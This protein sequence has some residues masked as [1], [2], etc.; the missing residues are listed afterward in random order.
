M[1][2][3]VFTLFTV[4]Y[5]QYWN[6]VCWNISEKLFFPLPWWQKENWVYS[7][8]VFC[9]PGP[10]SSGSVASEC[11]Y[12][13]KIAKW[14]CKW[15][16]WNSKTSRDI[17]VEFISRHPGTSVWNSLLS[18][19]LGTAAWNSPLFKTSRDIFLGFTTMKTREDIFVKFTTNKTSRDLLYR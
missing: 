9:K 11:S 14:V 2:E 7:C 8:G 13:F 3:V 10:I 18:K 5:M 4:V 15:S 17:S 1:E 12:S 6:I 19:H 16:L